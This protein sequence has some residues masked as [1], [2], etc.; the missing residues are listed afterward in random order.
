MLLSDQSTNCCPVSCDSFKAP[1]EWEVLDALIWYVFLIIIS[2]YEGH[3]SW[4]EMNVCEVTFVY[5]WIIRYVC[6][7]L[8]R[9][10]E[11]SACRLCHS[12]C[13]KQPLFKAL[14]LISVCSN[15][16][17]PTSFIAMC[18]NHFLKKIFFKLL[19]HMLKYDMTRSIL[20]S[21]SV[22]DL[23]HCMCDSHCFWMSDDTSVDLF[24][25]VWMYNK[26]AVCYTWVC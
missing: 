18:W 5:V 10:C 1:A 13:W 11:P 9:W 3:T 24:T 15:Q 26:A 16:T 19:N 20:A 2:C 22:Q 17:T 14:K 6:L 12:L 21:S 23:M 7:Q 4:S 25:V 8:L